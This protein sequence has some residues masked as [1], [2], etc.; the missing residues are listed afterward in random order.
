MMM[1][2]ILLVEADHDLRNPADILVLNQLAKGV[3]AV[4]G[5]FQGSGRDSARGNSDRA[6]HYSVHDEHVTALAATIH[7]VS[8]GPHE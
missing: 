2:E 3:Q 8:K 5:H 1:P 4:S 7:G 6:H